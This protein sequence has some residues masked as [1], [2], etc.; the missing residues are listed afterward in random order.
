MV[1][2]RIVRGLLVAAL[3]ALAVL[4]PASASVWGFRV[5]ADHPRDQA[6]FVTGVRAHLTAGENDPAG[7][8]HVA[9]DVLLA[10]GEHAC[11][12]LGRQPVALWRAGSRFQEAGLVARYLEEVAPVPGLDRPGGQLTNARAATA[13]AAWTYL[14]GPAWE[15]R[16]PHRL[17]ELFA[18][19]PHQ[20]GEDR[21]GH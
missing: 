18:P 10:E 21:N 1:A 14:C 8:D 5:R 3:V 2:V 9:G 11:R 4:A 16:R 13:Y 15:V 12:W 19:A 17:S 6:A 7:P 20:R